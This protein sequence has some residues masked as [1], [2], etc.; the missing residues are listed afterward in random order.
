MLHLRDDVNY[1]VIADFESHGQRVRVVIYDDAKP[2]QVPLVPKSSDLP[3]PHRG[4][5][6]SCAKPRCKRRQDEAEVFACA[7][8]GTCSLVRTEHTYC[9]QCHEVS[10]E[11]K[12]EF[13]RTFDV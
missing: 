12:A 2:L 9:L 6:V 3:C 11:L 4:E 13:A 1:P 8:H 7:L 10:R 5:N